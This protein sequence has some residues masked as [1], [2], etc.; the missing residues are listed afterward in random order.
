L[1]SDLNFFGWISLVL[2]YKFIV[3][4][5]VVNKDRNNNIYIYTKQKRKTKKIKIKKRIINKR[6]KGA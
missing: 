5:L 2:P 4:S 1:S 3:S 6:V